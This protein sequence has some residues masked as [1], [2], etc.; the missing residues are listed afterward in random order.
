MYKKKD[1]ALPQIVPYSKVGGIVTGQLMMKVEDSEDSEGIMLLLDNTYSWVNSKALK[2]S[3]EV[4]V[5]DKSDE[6]K[7]SEKDEQVNEETV[8]EE[9]EDSEC[10]IENLALDIND[11]DNLINL[12]RSSFNFARE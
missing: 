6:V 11:Q 1:G 12:L 2:Y 8:V 4:R 3:I 9:E 5:L 7:E 10:D